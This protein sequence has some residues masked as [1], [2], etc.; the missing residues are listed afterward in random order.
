MLRLTA[1][2]GNGLGAGILRAPWVRQM[3]KLAEAIGPGAVAALDNNKYLVIIGD[4]RLRYLFWPTQ[5][6]RKTLQEL[7]DDMDL[8]D[9]VAR[10]E[11][12]I[13]YRK[14]WPTLQEAIADYEAQVPTYLLEPPVVDSKLKMVKAGV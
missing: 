14:L 1:Q 9:F 2:A 6:S 4:L 13:S 8:A 7:K 3:Y 11:S 12:M 10:V 5:A